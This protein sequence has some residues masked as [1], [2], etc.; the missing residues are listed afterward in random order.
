MKSILGTAIYFIFT[1]LSL[2]FY[3]FAFVTAKNDPNS[4]YAWVALGA[5][6]YFTGRDI[7]TSLNY[8]V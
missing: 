4:S 3:G 6:V 5:A 8:T 7:R 2:G 1:T